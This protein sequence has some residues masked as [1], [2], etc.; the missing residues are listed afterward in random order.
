VHRRE[1]VRVRR[2]RR[3]HARRGGR[4]VRDWAEV[5]RGVGVRRVGDPTRRGPVGESD[6]R[7]HKGTSR[8]SS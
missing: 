4:A 2:R 5:R 1:V 3:S 7:V 6:H 8:R